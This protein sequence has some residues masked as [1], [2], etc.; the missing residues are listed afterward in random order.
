M[1]NNLEAARNYLKQ[2]KFSELTES[3]GDELRGWDESI[4]EL[5]ISYAA[6]FA[7]KRP[8]DEEIEEIADIEASKLGSYRSYTYELLTTQLKSFRDRIFGPDKTEG[9]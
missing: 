6:Q 8:S 3:E 5:M 9:E 2:F 4:P 1:E 7:P